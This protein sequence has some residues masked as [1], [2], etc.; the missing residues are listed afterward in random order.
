M[1]RR[2]LLYDNLAVFL[3]SIAAVLVLIIS[4]FTS[5]LI[6]SMSAFLRESIEER[7]LAASRSAAHLVTAE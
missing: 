7:L 2:T 3:F 5:I 4:I 6:S 1:T